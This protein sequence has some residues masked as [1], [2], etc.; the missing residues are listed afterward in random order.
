MQ[1]M[2]SDSPAP[3]SS[4]RRLLAQLLVGGLALAVPLAGHAAGGVSITSYGHSAL[5]IRGGG[6]TV[7]LNPFKAVGCAAGLS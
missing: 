2:A 4:R 5:L 3:A 1:P 7:L 6:A